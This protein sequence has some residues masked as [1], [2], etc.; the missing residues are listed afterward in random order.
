MATILVSINPQYAELIL[1]GKKK[2]EL[3]RVR[4]NKSVDRMVI[5]ATSPI[6]KV[7]G[8]CEVEKVVYD[9]PAG[10]WEE[11]GAVSGVSKEFFDRYYCNRELAV[12]LL[13][14]KPQR[15]LTSK[16][17]SAV[18]PG[19]TTPPQSFVYL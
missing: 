1:S 7:I 18:V 17:L 9:H 15:Y 11:F 4:F 8:E 3:R 5:Y 10:I 14:N 6:C 12:G 13:V 19:A 16:P 2:I